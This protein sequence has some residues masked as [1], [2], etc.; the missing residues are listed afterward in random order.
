MQ[1]KYIKTLYNST[2]KRINNKRTSKNIYFFIF[3]YS[4]CQYLKSHVHSDI[5]SISASIR[6]MGV[7]QYPPNTNIWIRAE[8]MPA[9]VSLF[10]ER[11]RATGSSKL[12]QNCLLL[13]S[14]K[15]RI[16]KF[17]KLARLENTHVH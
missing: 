3:P 15:Q 8:T 5:L 13:R 1:N 11:V 7:P 6:I 12:Q 10:I 4:F 17:S 16:S 2:V 9:F 14:F